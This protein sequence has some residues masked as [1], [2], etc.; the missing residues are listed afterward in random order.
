[1]SA[2]KCQRDAVILLFT[3]AIASAF[4][5]CRRELERLKCH[6]NQSLSDRLKVI[7][8]NLKDFSV[9][10]K[11]RELIDVSCQGRKTLNKKERHVGDRVKVGRFPERYY[12]TGQN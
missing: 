10:M 8:K 11:K 1:M 5:E 4:A 12:L 6:W 2:K 9:V 7:Y 3:S